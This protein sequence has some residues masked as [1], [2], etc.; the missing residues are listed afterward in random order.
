VGSTS[1]FFGA[2]VVAAVIAGSVSLFAPCCI[3]I[4]LPAYISSAFHNRRALVA[5]TF[6]FA[7]GVATVI[8]P[9]A[10]GA[11]FLQRI[12][13]T[14]H[15]L[16]YTGAGVL[17]VALGAYTLAGGRLH[18]PMPGR[19][20]SGRTGPLSV[21]SL[22][23]F[24]GVTSSCCAPVL[25]GVIALSGV[26]GSFAA[27]AGLGSAYVFGMVA[28]LFVISLLWERFD[29]RSTRLFRPRSVTWRLGRFRRTVSATALA[30]GVLLML[31]GAGTLY[32]GIFKNSMPSPRGWQASLSATLQHYG[33]KITHALSFVPGWVAAALLVLLLVVLARRALRQLTTSTDGDR[34]DEYEPE[35]ELR[36]PDA[37][38]TGAARSEAEHEYAT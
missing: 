37:R 4:M 6:L 24:S 35:L 31:M 20:A 18:L 27:A 22:G 30:S 19:S 3:S 26:A 32:I 16:I 29:L 2:S 17:L 25:A 12:F 9:I 8:V 7:A 38:A 15:T 11:A 1:I 10:V 13:V 23:I 21:Y 34:D 36:T 28:P 33:S 5:M 14:D